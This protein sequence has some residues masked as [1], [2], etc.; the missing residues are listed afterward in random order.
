MRGLRLVRLPSADYQAS[1]D[2][3]DSDGE[4]L[5]VLD[6][7]VDDLSAEVDRLNELARAESK[8][9]RFALRESRGDQL[10]YGW[11]GSNGMTLDP[12]LRAWVVAQASWADVYWIYCVFI[13]QPIRREQL[14]SHSEQWDVSQ[15][16]ESA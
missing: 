7:A 12:S 16:L 13:N 10:V 4:Y 9:P 8:E 15:S 1:I 3:A 6:G 14:S 5:L 11:D 2:P